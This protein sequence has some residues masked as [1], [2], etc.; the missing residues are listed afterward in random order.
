MI[1]LI[2]SSRVSSPFRHC[3]ARKETG[4]K[5]Y[6]NYAKITAKTVGFQIGCGKWI[7]VVLPSRRFVGEK[8]R[9]KGYLLK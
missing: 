7:Q 3:N 1:W 5:N 6:F 4:F 2:H 9:H 8:L